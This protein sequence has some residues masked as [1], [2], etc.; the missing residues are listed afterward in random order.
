MSSRQREYQKEMVA[1]GRCEVCGQ[2]EYVK[3]YCLRHYEARMARLHERRGEA[4]QKQTCAVCG[5]PGHNRRTCK[6]E[7]DGSGAEAV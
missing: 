6:S 2:A 5:Q 7:Q 1:Q 3:G 4:K